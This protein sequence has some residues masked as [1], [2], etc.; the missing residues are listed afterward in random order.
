MEYNKAK[1][2]TTFPTLI[3]QA[4]NTHIKIR[5]YEVCAIRPKVRYKYMTFITALHGV[6]YFF[7]IAVHL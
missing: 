3:L 6:D 1:A 7:T 4:V 5:M 2:A